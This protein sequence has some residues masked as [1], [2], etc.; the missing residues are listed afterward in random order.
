MV[1][2]G[3]NR[4]R[5]RRQGLTG[6]GRVG[7]GVMENSPV[8]PVPYE[9]DHS[10]HFLF[11]AGVEYMSR[12]GLGVRAEVISYD[13]DAQLGQLAL[14][15]RTDSRQQRKPVQIAEQTPPDEATPPLAAA[16]EVAPQP[17]PAQPAEVTPSAPAQYCKRLNGVLDGISFETDSARLT[18]DSKTRVLALAQQ[19]AQCDISSVSLTAHTDSQGS[20]EYN[21]RLSAKRA[22]AVARALSEGGISLQM[23][24]ARA[25]GESRPI[26][27]NDT[28]AG[29]QRNR[30]V[31]LTV[32]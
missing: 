5:A 10:S 25:F 24:R 20:A 16:L 30:R 19:L 22:R 3:R 6:Y 11:G 1:Y 28:A 8:G 27:T 2:A 17:V 32:K 21:Q 14:I 13:H 15:Y 7:Y 23:M 18:T 29:R 31:E 26:D 12:L 4:D 9:L